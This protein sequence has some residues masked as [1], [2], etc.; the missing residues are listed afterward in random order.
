MYFNLNPVLFD[1]SKTSI[2]NR[3]K[4]FIDICVFVLCSKPLLDLFWMLCNGYN[5]LTPVNNNMAGAYWLSVYSIGAAYFVH[6]KSTTP[7]FTVCYTFS[8]WARVNSG[9]LN[10]E[11]SKSYNGIQCNSHRSYYVDYT[12]MPLGI[13]WLI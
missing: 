10:I 3:Q 2:F 12:W 4:A 7:S 1:N 6:S 11:Y 8:L 9:Y 13:Y 5:Y